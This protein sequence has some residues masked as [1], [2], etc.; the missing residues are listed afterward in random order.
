MHAECE[1]P[2]DVA[3]IDTGRSGG[4]TRA[5][6]RMEHSSHRNSR[7][8][9]RL[10]ESYTYIH[11][12]IYIYIY[13]H[14]YIHIY[15][16]I[17]MMKPPSPSP[18]PSSGFASGSRVYAACTSLFPPP[19]G[20]CARVEYHIFAKIPYVGF[21][22]H[23]IVHTGHIFHPPRLPPRRRSPT[24]RLDS[25]HSL[26]SP[27]PPFP[28]PH[29]S[30]P[31]PPPHARLLLRAA[32]SARPCV[33]RT[34]WPHSSSSGPNLVPSTTASRPSTMNLRPSGRPCGESTCTTAF[35]APAKRTRRTKKPR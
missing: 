18:S 27:H 5:P 25:L 31:Q 8:E 14:T 24:C 7:P 12:Y 28:P 30:H 33:S 22:C 2:H 19:V 26:L 15:I 35:T 6:K 34:C 17:Y 23:V 29:L 4:G 9:N 10:S 3:R 13:I 16:Y 21:I 1:I 11:I 32:P 20:E